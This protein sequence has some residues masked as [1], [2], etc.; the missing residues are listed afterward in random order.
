M[1]NKL[2]YEFDN[3]E[4]CDRLYHHIRSTYQRAFKEEIEKIAREAVEPLRE[5]IRRKAIETLYGPNK[6]K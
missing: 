5:E 6:L 3:V 2:A 1:R 4:Y